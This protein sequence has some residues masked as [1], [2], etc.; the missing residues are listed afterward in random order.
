MAE[1]RRVREGM[2]AKVAARKHTVS[3]VFPARFAEQHT[4]AASGE[5]HEEVQLMLFG[6]VVYRLK[7]AEGD[8]EPVDWAGHATLVRASGEKAWRFAYYRVWIQR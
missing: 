7:G 3:Q 6:N 2:W 1:I 8:E 5:Q 4:C